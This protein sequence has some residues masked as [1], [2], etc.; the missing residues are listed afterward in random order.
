MGLKETFS[1]IVH[2][3]NSERSIEMETKSLGEFMLKLRQDETGIPTVCIF[4]W[5]KIVSGKNG[6]KARS[7]G[8]R[9]TFH[10]IPANQIVSFEEI[11]A[12]SVPLEIDFHFRNSITAI[13]RINFL[14]KTM[15]ADG[16]ITTGPNHLDPAV[17]PD[18]YNDMLEIAEKQRVKPFE[19]PISPAIQR[20]LPELS[21]STV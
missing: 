19:F 2:G 21:Q 12:D 7:Y 1:G 8:L 17:D 18:V 3:R 6:K 11:C 13:D 5:E 16:Y 10:A 15:G 20:T 14:A 4:P 9:Y